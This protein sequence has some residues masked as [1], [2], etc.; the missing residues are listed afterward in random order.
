MVVP[1]LP[2]LADKAAARAALRAER[3]AFAASLAPDTRAALEAELTR[4]LE[5]L[6]FAARV[7]AAYQ[8]MKDEIS[9]LAALDRAR[10]LGR[11]TALPAFAARDSRMTFR[12]GD[13]TEPGP[14]G[15]LQ[16]PLDHDPLVPDLVLVPLVGCDSRGNRIGMG[17]GHYDRALEALRGSARI[18]GIGWDFQLLDS[19]IAAD[20]WDQPLDAFASPSGLLE[21]AR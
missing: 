6:L 15:L 16:P 13:A 19:T 18:V 10:A 5:P 1:S 21:F 11:E 3:K 8:P 4:R 7:V 9:P 20:P 17:Q 12:P 2:S 14:W